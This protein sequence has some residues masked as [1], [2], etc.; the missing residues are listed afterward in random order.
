[1]NRHLFNWLLSIML[2]MLLST[3][4]LL[5]APSELEA[6]EAT[7]A[8]VIDAQQAAATDAAQPDRGQP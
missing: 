3:A 5:D 1:M 6:I 2:G 8:S 4:Y 7:A